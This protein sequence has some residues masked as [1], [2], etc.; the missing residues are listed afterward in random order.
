M[1]GSDRKSGSQLVCKVLEK[2][3]SEARKETREW[4]RTYYGLVEWRQATY[5]VSI[6]EQSTLRLAGVS[7][8][9]GQCGTRS[10][11]GVRGYL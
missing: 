8:Q 6:G 9:H 10:T 7:L 2:E 5:Q 11:C 1:R 3:S 4:E